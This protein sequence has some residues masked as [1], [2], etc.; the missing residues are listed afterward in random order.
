MNAIKDIINSQIYNLEEN[1]NSLLTITT[2]NDNKYRKI[3]SI[4]FLVSRKYPQLYKCSIKAYPIIE[5]NFFY[6][7]KLKL[8]YAVF[9]R[10][11]SGKLQVKKY[12]LDNEDQY[13]KLLV[14]LLNELKI[15]N[16]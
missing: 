8:K 7:S 6:D 14:L 9:L 5:C 10:L 16:N 1:L 15:K 12:P 4:K 11:K 2:L 13:N 3:N